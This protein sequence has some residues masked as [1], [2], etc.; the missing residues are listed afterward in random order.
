[1][2]SSGPACLMFLPPWPSTPPPL[3]LLLYWTASSTSCRRPY[4]LNCQL[5]EVYFLNRLILYDNRY[6]NNFND[7]TRYNSYKEIG[8]FK[9]IGPKYIHYTWLGKSAAM[10]GHRPTHLGVRPGQSDI[11]FPHKR[12]LLQTEILLGTRSDNPAGEIAG[13]GGPGL[14][15]L[16]MVVRLVERT[17][18][19]SKITFAAA[20]GKEINFHFSGNT[21]GHYCSQHANCTLPQ[22]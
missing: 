5:P 1:M 18:K 2:N 11:S 12:A 3:K 19:F 17:T 14:A 22:L 9:C 13:S 6:I 15:W 20:Y 21:T 8:Q 16:H 7:F 10:G 4:P